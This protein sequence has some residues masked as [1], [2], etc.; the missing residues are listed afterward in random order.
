MGIVKFGLFKVVFIKKVKELVLIL[1][2]FE[3]V[4]LCIDLFKI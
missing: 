4:K 2:L 1:K 3:S